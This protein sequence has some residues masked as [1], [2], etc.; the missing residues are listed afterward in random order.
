MTP[1][2]ARLAPLRRAIE[3]LETRRLLATIEGNVFTDVDADGLLDFFE[4]GFAGVTVFVDDNANF[5]L[6]DGEL[7]TQTDADGNYRFEDLDVAEPFDPLTQ[8]G[9]RTLFVSTLL[10]LDDDAEGGD[11]RI[12]QSSPGLPGRSNVEGQFNIDIEFLD[13]GLSAEQRTLF[14]VAVNRWEEV[15]IGDLADAGDVDDL[16]I[17]VNTSVTDGPG[18]T[19]ASAGPRSFR[20]NDLGG[21]PIT[22]AINIDPADISVSQGFV[23]TVVHEIGHILGIGTLWAANDLAQGQGS[24]SPV[25]TGENGVEEY[26]RLFPDRNASNVPVEGFRRL[27]DGGFGN[28]PGSSDSHWSEAE[29]TTELMTPNAT[30]G[31]DFFPPGDNVFSPL[32]RLTI[33]TLEDLGY[34]VSYLAAD[35]FGDALIGPLPEDARASVNNRPFQIGVLLEDES[36][37]VDDANF[38]VRRN[39]GPNDFLFNAGPEFVTAGQSVGL[40]AEIDN[41]FDPDAAGDDDFRDGVV[42]ANFYLES[43][44][45]AGLQTPADVR[46]GNAPSADTLLD[47]DAVIG[48]GFSTAF[49]TTGLA[50]GTYSLYAQAFDGG[51]FTNVRSDTI[52][53]VSDQD[54]PVRPTNLRA[55]GVDTNSFLVEFSDN[56]TQES[57]YLLQVSSDPNFDDADAID[58]VFFGFAPDLDPELVDRDFLGSNV[59]DRDQRAGTGTVRYVY[60]LPGEFDTAENTQRFFRVRS[61]NASASSAFAGRAEARTL[62]VGEARVDNAQTDRVEATGD[63]VTRSAPDLARGA[64]YLAGDNGSATFDVGGLLGAGD[65]QVFARTVDADD[66]GETLIELLRDGGVIDSLLVDADDAGSDQLLGRFTF[67]DGDDVRVRF[68]STG[69]GVATA[70]TVRLLPA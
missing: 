19:L 23:E 57:G 44:G 30:L 14:E 16:F 33:A 40:L 53:V 41:T 69:N 42:Q 31:A 22:G 32:S 39:T 27:D 45:L 5:Q 18:M 62:G 11:G 43:N 66:A 17:E 25:Y 65:F 2:T 46:R 13:Q 36:S 50:D 1:Q 4:D 61:F 6:D 9:G 55:I 60:D 58:E 67:A 10:E 56:D 34:E 47:E 64:T 68:S 15:I 52:T 28:D 51:Y 7:S 20:A 24:S 54:D 48:D 12:A 3:T 35:V 59:L 26:N 49:D 37:V 70:D 38:G 21:L 29:L 63:F 8:E